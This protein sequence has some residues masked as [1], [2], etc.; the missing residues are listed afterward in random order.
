MTP[1]TPRRFLLENHRTDLRFAFFLNGF[2]NPHLVA[3]TGR[4][5]FPDADRPSHGR[6]SLTG[7][8]TE[9]LVQWTSARSTRGLVRW[10]TAPGTYQWGVDARAM[11]YTRDDLCGGLAA[12]VRRS[13]HLLGAGRL[14]E[15]GRGL[16]HEHMT[17]NC[18]VTGHHPD[19][20]V[21]PD[22]AHTGCDPS[23][24]GSAPRVP[25]SA[26]A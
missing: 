6:L 20:V 5:R 18:S 15:G 3:Q 4:I 25:L 11:T 19:P 24:A 9:M 10:G 8:P 1:V 14:W 22:I 23:L 16:G 21:S 26:A 17:C 7:N 12:N 13:F 2:A